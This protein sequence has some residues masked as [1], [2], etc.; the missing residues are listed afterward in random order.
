MDSDDD[1]LSD[2]LEQ[3]LLEQFRPAFRVAGSDCAG[4]PAAFKRDDP[5]PVPVREDGTIYGQAF[6][7]RGADPQHPA[8]EVHYYHLWSRDCGAHGHPLDT[9]HVAV[10][11]EGSSGDLTRASWKAAYWYA[12]AHENTVCDVSQITRASAL[13]AQERGAIVWISPDKHASY[14]DETLCSHGCGADRCA[15]MKALPEGRIVNLG[16]PHHPMNGAVFAA[17]AQWP[18]MAKMEGTNFPEATLARMRQLPENEIALYKPGKHPVQGVIAISASTEQAIAASGDDTTGA[19]GLAGDKTTGALGLA[20]DKTGSALGK[21]YRGTTH[22]LGTSA[23][24][25][26]KALGMGSKPKEPNVAAPPQE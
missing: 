8:V 19:V 10:L 20:G 22:A 21:S 7:R 11:L 1:G 15:V 13:H 26:G 6:P 16:E 24:H 17:S 18:L 12:A 2:R 25:V 14:L 3:S 23:R 9:E 5:S 4:L